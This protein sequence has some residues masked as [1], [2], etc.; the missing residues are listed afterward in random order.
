[1]R[2][3]AD[4]NKRK[5][6]IDR[7]QEIGWELESFIYLVNKSALSAVPDSAQRSPRSP[8]GGRVFAGAGRCANG[9]KGKEAGDGSALLD[10]RL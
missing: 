4:S 6:E 5:R 8:W 10:L 9:S 2:E 3:Q 1:M 7:V